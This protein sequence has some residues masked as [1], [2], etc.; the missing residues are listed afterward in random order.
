[1]KNLIVIMTCLL[2]TKLALAENCSNEELM[3]Y[4]Q[5]NSLLSASSESIDERFSGF[6]SSSNG[7][8]Y[9]FFVADLVS[10]SGKREIARVECNK[11]TGQK[12]MSTS[13]RPGRVV[14]DASSEVMRAEAIQILSHLE[15]RN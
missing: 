2:V 8:K 15:G 13:T 5:S 7:D 4:A 3:A 10:M 12:T 11:E 1:M 14:A 9:V 6:M